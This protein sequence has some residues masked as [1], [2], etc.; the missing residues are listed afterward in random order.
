MVVNSVE[1]IQGLVIIWVTLGMATSVTMR[2][3]P[4]RRE[5]GVRRGGAGEVGSLGHSLEDGAGR[6]RGWS[7]RGQ[8]LGSGSSSRQKAR[9]SSG[10]EHTGVYMEF[11][12]QLSFHGC[13]IFFLFIKSCQL[14]SP[15]VTTE[16]LLC[17]RFCSM[18]WGYHCEKMDRILAFQDLPI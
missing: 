3:E 17:A 7:W 15:S 13:S 18:C 9:V 2:Q 10:C 11:V 6:W 14:F 1:E 8:Q 12:G 16:H 4:E 5:L